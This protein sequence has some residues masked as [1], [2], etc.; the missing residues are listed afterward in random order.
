MFLLKPGIKLMNQLKY[1]YKFL[2]LGVIVVFSFAIFLHSIVSN[3]NASIEFSGKENYGV[4]YLK[5]LIK[6]LGAVQD[7]RAALNQYLNG[8]L[9]AKEGAAAIA[10]KAD[11]IS[12]EVSKSDAKLNAELKSSE[13]WSAVKEKWNALKNLKTNISAADNL[14]RHDEL[15]AGILTLIIDIADVSNLTLDPDVDSYYLMDSVCTKIPALGENIAQ[16]R[17]LCANIGLLKTISADEKTN[18]VVIL[19]L[20]KS[21]LDSVSLNMKRA[22]DYN[23]AVT[24]VIQ[25]DLGACEKSV[26][27][28]I[29]GVNEKV[30]N[31]AGGIS[32]D[33]KEFYDNGAM[34]LLAC[35]KLYDTELAML[36]KLIDIRVAGYTSKKT[37]MVIFTI[38]TFLIL[39]YIMASFY[40][41]TAPVLNSLSMTA[42]KIAA[43]DIDQVISYNSRDEIGSL[44]DSFRNMVLYVKNI[45]GAAES[46]AKGEL[47]V[48]IQPRS[49]KDLLALNFLK[50]KEALNGLMDE[51]NKITRAVVSGDIKMRA[52]ARQF[53]GAYKNVC[54][55][56]NEVLDIL[57]KTIDKITQ[58]TSTLASSSEEL[59]SVS[60]QMTENAS[61]TS[62]MAVTVSKAAEQSQKSIQMV[63]TGTQEMG[64]SIKEIAR[65]TNEAV[66]MA[67]TAVNVAKTANDTVLKLGESSIEIGKVIK[68]INSIAEQTN[69]LA[70]N[71]TIE[72]ARAG[73][74]GKGFAVVANE[75]K[76]LAKE[77]AK[78]TEDISR[79]I[80]TIQ[81]DTKNSVDA[82][83]QITGIINQIND[84]QNT[85]ASAVEQQTATTNEIN[86]NI[87][88]VA[89]GSSE[90]AKNIDVVATAAKSTEAGS[91]DTLQASRDLAKMATELQ[92]LVNQFKI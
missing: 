90:I 91:K 18:L 65:N 30:L 57:F 68:V 52:E 51:N 54:N 6:F 59:T 86:H 53:S 73:E 8:E 21:N 80:E 58:Y 10:V 60:K 41:S 31:A 40:Y 47:S 69:L 39:F 50:V 74:A 26:E 88:D 61:N 12:E 27:S 62:S 92:V 37:N 3:L 44:S 7:H 77:T 2:L 23:Q 13:K 15:A 36:E 89:S 28:F 33:I 72:A 20:L 9:A 71:A 43:G 49:D 82:I 79:K 24:P 67:T 16:L 34:A 19:G 32:F 45:A 35:Y 70:L 29:A 64:S 46:I 85:I 14:I 76:E 11:I 42:G 5:P 63:A 78:A 84:F 4:E 55:G 66:K 56:L 83:G 22:F 17:N 81:Q 25:P 75:V 1:T 38:I 87:N 48:D